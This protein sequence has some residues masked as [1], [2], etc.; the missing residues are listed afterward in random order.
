MEQFYVKAAGVPFR[1]K[2]FLV[3]TLMGRKITI[4]ANIVGKMVHLA[5]QTKP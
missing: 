1:S 2:G 5:N 4:I 3:Q